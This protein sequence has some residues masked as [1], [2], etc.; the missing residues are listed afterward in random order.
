VIHPEPNF[1]EPGVRTAW[2][3]G[4]KFGRKRKLTP[5]HVTDARK[6]IASGQS[7]D[8]V[9]GFYCVSRATLFR[10]LAA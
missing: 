4:F 8:R 2:A 3:R 7:P 6:K 9:A 10:A 5:A 1:V